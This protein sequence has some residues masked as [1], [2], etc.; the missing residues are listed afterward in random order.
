M[1]TEHD[2]PYRL[3]NMSHDSLAY[4]NPGASSFEAMLVNAPSMPPV[5]R[6]RKTGKN[7]ATARQPA[8]QQISDSKI[9]VAN[10]N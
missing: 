6:E 10:F 2:Y 1:N 3:C 7:T 9:P 4:Y 8:F 5:L